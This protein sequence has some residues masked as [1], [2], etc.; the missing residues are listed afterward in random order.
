MYIITFKSV[1]EP[2]TKAILPHIREFSPLS[3]ELFEWKKIIHILNEMPFHSV[4]ET[5]IQ[6]S[7]KGK[8]LD[9]KEIKSLVNNPNILRLGNSYEI[10][11]CNLHI[12]LYCL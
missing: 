7:D 9:G 12:S 3:W 8:V 6:K 11:H 1:F 4:F 10:L 5:G 2:F